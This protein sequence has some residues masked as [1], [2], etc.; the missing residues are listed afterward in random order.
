MTR[1]EAFDHVIASDIFNKWHFFQHH[2]SISMRGGRNPLAESII[3]LCCD[4]ERIIKGVGVD[5][6][7]K[8]AAIKGK[9]NDTKHY[10]QLMQVLAEMIVV[11]KAITFS[12]NADMKFQ[13]EPASATSSK[14]PELTIKTPELYFGIEV[15]APEMVKKHNE[16]GE[17][18]KQLPSRSPMIDLV[19]KN[20]TMLPRD[21][22]VKDFLI[23]A[24]AKFAG[25]KQADPNFYGVLVI[26][27]D[28]F[29]YEPISALTS[30]Q[31]GLFTS[32]SFA[33]DAKGVSLTFPN[34]DCVI[35]TRHLLLI[36]NGTRDKILPDLFRHPLD[37]GRSGEFP[38]K[39]Y[40]Q[41]PTS[42]LNVP[43][44]IIDCFQILQPDMRLGAEYL[45]I[46][47]IQWF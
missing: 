7:N 13:Y 12:W 19:D 41:N 28:D 30:P 5:Y 44:Q 33:T 3:G 14:N 9:P 31:S 8:I 24:D 42:Q 39:V 1:K 34:V 11:H 35:V 17:K 21:N 2:F 46:D 45:P 29:I 16:R 40:F 27:W 22:P 36:K 15:K 37:Y 4:M 26:V 10:D 47:F 38:F 6:F 43:Q 25:F 18:E 20:M 23:S 32:N